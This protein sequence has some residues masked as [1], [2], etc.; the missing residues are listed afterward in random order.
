MV[1]RALRTSGTVQ[2]LVTSMTIATLSAATC[3]TPNAVAELAVHAIRAEADL[4]PKPG[5]V[6]Q[7]GSGAHADMDVATLHASAESLREAFAECA[8]AA[9]QSVAW[10]ELRYRLGEIGRAGETAMLAATGGVN[11]HRGAL[12]ALGLLSAGAVLGRSTA[13]AVDIAARL[14]SIPDRYSAAPTSN[15]ARARRR[16]GVS[17]AAGEAQAGFPHVRLYA[18]PALRTARRAGMD[19][20]SARLEA[21]LA[22]MATLDDT[23][24]LHRGGATGLSAVQDGARKVLAAG[25][26]STPRG[27]RHFNAL[28]DTCLSQRLSP[29]GSGDLLAVTMFLDALDDSALDDSALDNGEAQ[30]CKP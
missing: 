8:S 27:R 19:E 29:G 6:D 23:C 2:G 24:I 21:L 20:A 14:A 26:I 25:G 4:T 30:P 11:T 28:D 5:L 7:R 10:P 18:L 22:L 3:F 9:A 15:G 12:W 16:F 13:D 1:R 17:G